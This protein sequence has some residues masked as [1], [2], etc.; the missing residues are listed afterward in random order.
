MTNSAKEKLGQLLCEKS[1]LDTGQLD[2]ALEEQKGTRKRLGKILLDLGYVTQSQLT[3]ALAVQVDIEYAD[4][5]EITMGRQ[6]ISLV[7]AD[8]VSK[9]NILP[10]WQRDGYIAVAMTDPFDTQA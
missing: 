5:S 3:E 10:L 2:Q 7:P 6:L 9:Y 4:L 1:Y 8:L